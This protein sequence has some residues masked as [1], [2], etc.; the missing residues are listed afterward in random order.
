MKLTQQT[1]SGVQRYI[2]D[3]PFDKQEFAM[4]A[5][6]R[7]DSENRHWY[8]TDVKVAARLSRLAEGKLREILGAIA[9]AVPLA[10]TLRFV[11]G[12]YIFRSDREHADL[13]RNADFFRDPESGDWYTTDPLYALR[14]EQYADDECRDR[15]RAAMAEL[16]RALEE[17]HAL[18]SDLE[19]P[20]PEGRNYFPHQRAAVEYARKVLR[21]GDPTLNG[22]RIRGCLV[23]D[24]MRCGKTPATIGVINLA[25]EAIQK[26]LI[27][28]PAGVKLGWYRELQAWLVNPRK[29]LI[30]DSGTAAWKFE[31]AD[32]SI[33]NFDI[34]KD[35]VVWERK[36]SRDRRPLLRSLGRLD[37][38]WDLVIVDEAHLL[39]N[40]HS[41]RSIVGYTLLDRARRKLA[42]T[43]TPITNWID[44]L[45]PLLHALDPSAWPTMQRFRARYG[46]GK[47]A[48]NLEELKRKIRSSIMV[49]RRLRDVQK[50]LP[51][52]LR[53]VLE[54]TADD[55][56]AMRAVQHEKAAWDRQ[57]ERLIALQAAAE[58]A[59]A[60]DDDRAHAEASKRLG[61]GKRIA[62]TETAKLRHETARVKVP[63]VVEHLKS[64]I[65][66][67]G[68]KV[69]VG[70]WHADVIEKLAEPFGD[71]AVTVTGAVSADLKVVDGRESSERM[72]R[73][74]R[75]LEDSRCQ[76]FFGN[77]VAAGMGLNLSSASHIVCAELWYVPWVMQQFEARC[78]HPTKTSSIFVQHLVLAGSIDAR[79][80]RALLEKQ[81][82]I[83][84]ALDG[85]SVSEDLAVVDE[86]ATKGLTR[87]MIE[88]QAD[89]MSCS[90]ITAIH[91]ALKSL[92]GMNRV[93]AQIARTLAGYSILTA[94]QAVLGAKLVER[95]GE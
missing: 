25:G 74:D 56:A 78:E 33:I 10:P 45:Y 40:A 62:F 68:Y 42:L 73:V 21:I 52:K 31:K 70:A 53:E 60:S 19:I 14:L 87:A 32:I 92:S 66:D 77:L 23:G 50:N 79:I 7:R 49:R 39:K 41:L 64:L 59:K 43:G 4:S 46:S 3:C 24:E 28:C 37:V 16:D 29:I 85:A 13:A 9:S 82:I 80:A 48:R 89:E 83:D 2:L 38:D 47:E 90:D 22:D 94:R 35:L 5:G 57:Q 36:A 8:T 71:R 61:E 81:A 18:D 27:I 54:F 11:H 75:F 63:Y 72:R 44:D 15:V 1:I 34:L 30:A 67:P 95:Y 58:L 17:S 69:V 6:F 12:R 20:A 76:V 55:A 86:P 91:R 51:P 65:E 93:D 84:K 26:M 88:R